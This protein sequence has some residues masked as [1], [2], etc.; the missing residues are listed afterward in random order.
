MDLSSC[1]E[2]F[3]DRTPR[4]IYDTNSFR[5]GNE[6]DGGLFLAIARINH[7]CRPNVNHFWREDLQKTLIFATRDI[8][9]GEE[10]Y[11][12]YGPSECMSTRDR[13]EYLSDRFSFR[14]MCEMCVEG[15]ARGGDDRMVEIKSLQEDIALS[16]STTLAT[17][18]AAVLDSVKKSLA[19]MNEQGIG[20]GVFLKSIYHQGY[21][22]CMAAGDDEGARSYLVR[23][24]KA[25]QDSE[26]VDSPRAIEIEWALM[27]A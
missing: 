15:N 7:S 24:L 16:S 4:G 13:R 25:V 9:V 22:V 1:D 8:R 26:G 23:E 10:L 14:C 11:T 5:L 27:N 17:T 19:L 3:D 2:S 21:D 18:A 12:T 6:D 20:G